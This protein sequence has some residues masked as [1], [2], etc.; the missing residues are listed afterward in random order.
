MR[1]TLRYV[2]LLIVLV[3]V[4]SVF[5][6]TLFR[7]RYPHPA[8]PTFD[9]EVSRLYLREIESQQP[10]IVLLGDSLLTKGVDQVVFQDQTGIPTYKLDIPGS[11]S[12]L[13]YLVLRSN[14]VPA[15]PAPRML[16]ILLIGR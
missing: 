12:A 2:F 6:P 1:P 14:I 9:R 7:G 13:W 10:G 3:L 15:E 5:L 8:G 11:S 4:T 16:V